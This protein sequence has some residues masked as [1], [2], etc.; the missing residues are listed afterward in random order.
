M[1]ASRNIDHLIKGNTELQLHPITWHH[2]KSVGGME[3]SDL[4][5]SFAPF[6]GGIVCT[7]NINKKVVFQ[8]R[9]NNR[10]SVL[11]SQNGFVP[12]IWYYFFCHTR[13][14]VCWSWLMNE[15][16][17]HLKSSRRPFSEIL[18]ALSLWIP[19]L[20][21][22]SNV[23]SAISVDDVSWLSSASKTSFHLMRRFFN[24]HPVIS[25]VISLTLSIAIQNRMDHNEIKF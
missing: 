7:F 6:C 23:W 16:G 8:L 17:Q 3:N 21:A 9:F 22:V 14:C 19:L 4:P 20:L 18:L 5:I 1:S 2:Y 13:E 10:K 11:W 24:R 15:D 12:V 25:H